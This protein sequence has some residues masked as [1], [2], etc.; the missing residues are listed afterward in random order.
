MYRA[1]YALIGVEPESTQKRTKPPCCDPDTGLPPGVDGALV[2]DL[3]ARSRALT[4]R[5]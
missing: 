2:D 4:H 5:R 3:V 1:L